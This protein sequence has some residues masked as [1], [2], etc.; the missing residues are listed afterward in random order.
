MTGYVRDERRRRILHE[1]SEE[2]EAKAEL[3]ERMMLSHE[4]FGAFRIRRRM[5]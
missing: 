2:T 5:N 4:G 1:L 3:L